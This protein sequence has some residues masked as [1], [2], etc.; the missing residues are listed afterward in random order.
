MGR[1][2][3]ANLV[4]SNGDDKMVHKFWFAIQDSDVSD[5]LETYA[6]KGEPE[7]WEFALLKTN[8]DA[9]IKATGAK[10][11]R[12]LRRRF[13]WTYGQVMEAEAAWEFS[14]LDVVDSNHDML[15]LA[16]RINLG[17]HL[18]QTIKQMRRLGIQEQELLIEL[19]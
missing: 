19:L 4:G 3:N 16:S 7:E 11:K 18:R 12:E 1:F 13:G 14:E 5:Y 9:A 10:L 17:D 2:I 8:H 15:E 6:V